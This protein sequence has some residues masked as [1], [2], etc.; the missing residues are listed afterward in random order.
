MGVVMIR[1]PNTEK[2]IST[3]LQMDRAAFRSMPVF[4]RNTFCPLCR[5]THEWFARSAWVC[6]YGP[7]NCDPNCQRCKMPRRKGSRG[8]RHPSNEEQIATPRDEAAP[9]AR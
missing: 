8:E 2:S 7:E 4:F 9:H 1:C 5:T 3:G 6:D